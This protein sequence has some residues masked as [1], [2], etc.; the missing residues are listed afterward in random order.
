MDMEKKGE[1]AK[2][3]VMKLKGIADKEGCSVEDLVSRYSEEEEGEEMEGEDEK[4]KMIAARMKAS[5]GE[6]A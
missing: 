3:L 2:E 6:M 5:S 1:S 4:V